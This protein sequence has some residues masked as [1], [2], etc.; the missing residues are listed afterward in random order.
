MTR[1]SPAGQQHI[2]KQPHEPYRFKLEDGTRVH[3]KTCHAQNNGWW[4]GQNRY[5]GSPRYT[6]GH[7]RVQV[8]QASMMYD[9]LAAC[10]CFVGD[11]RHE[12]QG[13]AR[14][15]DLPPSAVVTA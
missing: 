3:C 7:V 8:P 13:V 10:D 9:T 4:M 14:V 15:E 12:Q 2:E 6:G 5:A 1:V 11:L